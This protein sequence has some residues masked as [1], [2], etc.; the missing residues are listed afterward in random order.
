M[1]QASMPASQARDDEPVHGYARAIL[2]VA[3]A[4]DAVDA[5][6]DELYRFARAVESEPEL[7]DRLA[8]PGVD[9][10]R[11]VEL[12]EELLSGRAHPQTVAA[13]RLVVQSDRG[14]QL[15]DVIDAF[16]DLAARSRSESLA[17]ARTAVEL[18]DDQR[19]ALTDA[20]SAMTGTE[21]DLKVVVDPDVVGGVVVKVGDTVVDGSVARRLS[22]LRARLTGA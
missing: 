1:T 12:V 13:V 7:R 10:G 11:K 9:A 5:V 22:E 20:I 2:S 4:E 19:R 6:E 21:V 16:V 18:D 17:E 8:D 15:T 14:R 3:L